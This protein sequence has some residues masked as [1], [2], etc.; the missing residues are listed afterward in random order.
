MERFLKKTHYL[1]AAILAVVALIT[2]LAYIY[3]FHNQNISAN[4][5]D[6]GSFGDYFS[7]IITGILTP[8]TVYLVWMTYTSQSK[9]FKELRQ[10][11]QENTKLMGQ[12]SF[13]QTFFSWMKSIKEIPPEPT[14]FLIQL[15]SRICS[16]P[17]INRA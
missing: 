12:Q 15:E 11:N 4:T 14:P 13:E 1:I 7:G 9:E 10:I 16:K 2:T 6:W 8:V 3:F 5:S 17:V